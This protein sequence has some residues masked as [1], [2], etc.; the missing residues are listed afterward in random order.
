MLSRLYQHWPGPKFFVYVI[1][2]S[3]DSTTSATVRYSRIPLHTRIILRTCK[4]D[5]TKQQQKLLEK[6]RCSDNANTA[7]PLPIHILP[8][9]T[10]IMLLADIPLSFVLLHSSF[11]WTAGVTSPLY[12]LTPELHW[13]TWWHRWLMTLA[14]S[15]W[16]LQTALMSAPTELICNFFSSSSPSTEKEKAGSDRW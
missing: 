9:Y 8:N 11:M 2:S 4:H 1:K 15:C 3:I 7:P 12:R 16:P 6:Q 13:E 14:E 10:M 5:G